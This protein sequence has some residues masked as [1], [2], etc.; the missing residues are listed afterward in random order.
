M[1]GRF[2]VSSSHEAIAYLCGVDADVVPPI[3][4]R[5]NIAPTQPIGTVRLDEQGKRTWAVVRWGLIPSWA[6]DPAVGNRMINARSE[7]VAETPA[8]RAS[9]KRRRCLIPADGFYEW[10][11]TGTKHK[12]PHVIRLR[13]DKPFAF[14]GLWDCWHSPDGEVI[15]S[16]TILT[17]S[18]NDLLRPLHE[19]MPVILR[20]ESL[21]VWLDPALQT[22]DDLCDL[23]KPYPD[24]EMSLYAVDSY[25]S[26]ARNQGPR[27]IE[28]AAPPDLFSEMST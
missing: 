27:C 25:V 26:N 22:H 12:T 18:A 28:P 8:F 1:C 17:T 20:S 9:F 11:S 16:A 7:T 2:L 15:E 14:A 23:F 6:K 13:D 21:S 19:R 24:T 4:P 5:Y 3:E 10:K